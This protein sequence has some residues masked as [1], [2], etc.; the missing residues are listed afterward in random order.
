M[1]TK[2]NILVLGFIGSPRRN[3]N[4]EILVDEVL[5]GAKQG[6]ARTE[7]I[8]LNDLT[9]HPCQAC[10][11]C[12]KTN[13]CKYDDDMKDIVVKMRESDIWVLGTPIYWWGPTAQ[14]KAFIDRWYGLSRQL[15]VGKKIILVLPSGGGGTFYSR[16]T[17]GMFED[18]IPYLSMKLID[19]I[20]AAG[21][22]SKGEARNVLPLME[23]A[24]KAGLEAI[25]K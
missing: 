21:I 9:I 22:G 16:H 18:I 7:K 1:T 6:G 13:V 17:L 19:T 20:L 8:I 12:V 5:K 25:K 4:T 2:E 11:A 24:R 23:K 10:N 15:F 14:I 3:G